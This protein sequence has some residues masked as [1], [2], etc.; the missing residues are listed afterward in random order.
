[1]G[2][3][4]LSQ[5]VLI[6]SP[7]IHLATRPRDNERIALARQVM[8]LV[9]PDAP[10]TATSAFGAHLARR[11]ELYFFPG[12]I[13]YPP[14]LAER[15][16]YLLADLREV[17]PEAMGRLHAMQESESWR[18]QFEQGGFL[19]LV[20]GTGNGDREQETGSDE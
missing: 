9:P 18:V 1:V 4:L 16:E 5:V 8:A 12:N 14:E 15:G 20:R 13:I 6:R 7:L 17:P 3:A 19:L 2:V 10:L 11:H